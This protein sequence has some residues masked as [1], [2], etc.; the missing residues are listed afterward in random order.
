MGEGLVVND[1]VVHVA[2]PFKK[3]SNSKRVLCLEL[4]LMRL[5]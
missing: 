3:K 2:Q 4:N 5:S 1:H